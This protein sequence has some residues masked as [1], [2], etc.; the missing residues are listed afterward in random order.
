MRQLPAYRTE[1]YNSRELVVRDPG[2][3]GSAAMSLMASYADR[4]YEV[5]TKT[6]EVVD[7]FSLTVKTEAFGLSI[8]LKP[9]LQNLDWWKLYRSVCVLKGIVT[10]LLCVS[11]AQGP[12]L[13]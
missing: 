6:R 11:T 10:F 9:T 12:E 8:T 13:G 3:F 1:H 2:P 4:K 7:G 5:V